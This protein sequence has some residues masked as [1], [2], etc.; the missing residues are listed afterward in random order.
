MTKQ[1]EQPN[2]FNNVAMAVTGAVVGAGIIVAGAI[3][4][5]DKKN[6]KIV[7][8]AFLNVKDQATSYVE[9]AQDEAK[10]KID[11]VEEK[12]VKS[13]KKVGKAV[14]AAKKELE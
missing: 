11:S 5:K 3:A 10:D 2:N 9:N 13:K 8:N 7:K 4:L 14:V 12:I 6:R 1:I